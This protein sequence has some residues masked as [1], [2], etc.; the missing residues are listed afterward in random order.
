MG[1]A[2]YIQKKIERKSVHVG[3]TDPP[4]KLSTSVMVRSRWLGGSVA[5]YE[6][7]RGAERKVCEVHPEGLVAHYK[8]EKGAE[9][10]VRVVRPDGL[11]MHLEGERGA[12]RLVHEI[13]ALRHRARS[14][15]PIPR[16]RPS[17]RDR[18]RP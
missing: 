16:T 3:Y 1:H 9:H 10:V 13:F 15:G 18:S 5:H 6:G 14:S 2:I 8:G 11:V 12:E 7:E 17:V 4:I